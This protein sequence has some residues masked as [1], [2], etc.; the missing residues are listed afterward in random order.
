VHLAAIASL[1]HRQ[2]HCLPVPGA[3]LGG[4]SSS[5]KFPTFVLGPRIT[6]RSNLSARLLTPSLLVSSTLRLGLTI[7]NK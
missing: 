4:S 6:S 3:D 2:P 1:P 7:I 5:I